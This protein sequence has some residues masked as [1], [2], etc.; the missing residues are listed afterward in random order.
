MIAKIKEIIEQQIRPALQS[1]G[2]DIELV[3]VED[4]IVK[5]RLVGACSH[6]PSSA[7]TLYQG[8]EKMLMDQMP[9]VKGI[10]QVW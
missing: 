1:D 4:G 5:V 9:E 2:G 8:V 10:E 7:M 6:C 3:D